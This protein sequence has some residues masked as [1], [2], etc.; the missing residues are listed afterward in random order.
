VDM[1]GY[2]L[3]QHASRCCC[4]CRALPGVISSTYKVATFPLLLD[5]P[6]LAQTAQQCTSQLS[7]QMPAAK[8]VRPKHSRGVSAGRL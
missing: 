1:L 2:N 4:C 8:C 7:M 6:T 5:F 3:Y